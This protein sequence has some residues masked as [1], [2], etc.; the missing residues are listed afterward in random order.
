MKP[1]GV[2]EADPV[3]DGTRGVL[4]GIEAITMHALIFQRSDNK[5]DHTVLLWGVRRDKPQSKTVAAHH[6][7]VRLRVEEQPVIQSQQ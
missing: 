1:S 7:P 2:A 6:A 5:F 4:L 3:S